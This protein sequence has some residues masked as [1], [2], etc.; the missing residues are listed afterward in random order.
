MQPTGHPVSLLQ[1]KFHCWKIQ[2]IPL[3]K[4]FTSDEKHYSMSIASD[5]NILAIRDKNGVFVD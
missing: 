4:S 3:H 5:N 1:S 2:M